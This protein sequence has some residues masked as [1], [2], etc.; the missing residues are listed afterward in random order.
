MS[1]SRSENAGLLIGRLTPPRNLLALSRQARLDRT[2]R[3][4][5]LKRRDLIFPLELVSVQLRENQLLKVGGHQSNLDGLICL[6]RPRASTGP[7]AS[8]STNACSKAKG[9]WNGITYPFRELDLI[10]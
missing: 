7:S 10:R 6:R 3:D 9:H 2:T 5:T 8:K 4:P 1:Q